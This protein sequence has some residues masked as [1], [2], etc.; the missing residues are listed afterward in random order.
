MHRAIVMVPLLLAVP[1]QAADLS[2]KETPVGRLALPVLPDS[3][4]Y[5]PGGIPTPVLGV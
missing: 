4:S 3:P 5:P 2:I 1:L